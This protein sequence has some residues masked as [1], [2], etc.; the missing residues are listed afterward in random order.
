MEKKLLVL[1]GVLI[2]VGLYCSP[3]FAGDAMGP[4]TAGLKTGQYRVGFDY[5]WAESDVDISIVIGADFPADK[6]R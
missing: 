2:L 6:V 4:P 5:A 3:A 1:V